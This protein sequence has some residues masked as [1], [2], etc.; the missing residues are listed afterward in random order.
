MYHEFDIP[1]RTGGTGACQPV[2][3]RTATSSND[4]SG[5]LQPRH[6]GAP[7]HPLQRPTHAAGRPSRAG[8]HLAGLARADRLKLRAVA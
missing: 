6:S 2:Q 8:D 4:R 7:G 5:S 3:P 1:I